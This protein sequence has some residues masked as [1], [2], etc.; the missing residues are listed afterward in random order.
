MNMIYI[1]IYI[2]RYDIHFAKFIIEIITYR[3]DPM[4]I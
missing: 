4:M 3:V 2:D 1:I